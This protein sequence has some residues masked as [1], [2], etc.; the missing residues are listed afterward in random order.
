MVHKERKS[1]LKEAIRKMDEKILMSDLFG[2]YS[3][4]INVW[5]IGKILYSEN[6]LLL[7]KKNQQSVRAAMESGFLVNMDTDAL[8]RQA[9]KYAYE[10][11]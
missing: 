2:G 11:E 8:Y 1:L 6:K 4:E 5:V 7:P 10:N 3:L 9:K